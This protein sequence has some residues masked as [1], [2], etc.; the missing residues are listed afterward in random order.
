MTDEQAPVVTAAVEGFDFLTDSGKG[1]YMHMPVG[2]PVILAD[3]PSNIG[4][5]TGCCGESLGNT[6][7]AS[8]AILKKW[9]AKGYEY[10]AQVRKGADM[11]GMGGVMVVWQPLTITCTPTQ[12][13][14]GKV[15]V[16]KKVSEDA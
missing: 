4:C 16:K 11:M 7:A 9:M 1:H 8:A 3:E 5:T 12:K 6:D 14:G 2:A 10:K 15:K 13:A